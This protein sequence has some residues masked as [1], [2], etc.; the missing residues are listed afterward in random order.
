M[1][2]YSRGVEKVMQ[3]AVYMT[4]LRQ[5]EIRETEIPEMK[6]NEVLVVWNM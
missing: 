1:E 5:M 4:G 2:Y 3:K 6:E